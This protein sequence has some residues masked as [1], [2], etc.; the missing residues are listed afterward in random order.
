M[1]AE[2]QVLILDRERGRVS[3]GHEGE[4]LTKPRDSAHEGLRLWQP[5]DVFARL[6]L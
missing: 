1:P 2:I 6:T 4:P 3:V 5:G